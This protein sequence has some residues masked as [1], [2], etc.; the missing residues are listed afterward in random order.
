MDRICQTR[1]LAD[2]AAQEMDSKS[3]GDSPVALPNQQWCA[4]RLSILDVYSKQHL[5]ECLKFFLWHQEAFF[6]GNAW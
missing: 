2:T 1:S 6:A 3:S 4:L 5:N